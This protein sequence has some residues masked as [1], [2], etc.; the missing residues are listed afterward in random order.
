MGYFRAHKG[1]EVERK[2]LEE[3]HYLRL[4]TIRLPNEKQRLRHLYSLSRQN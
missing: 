3:E 4:R 1:L 2:E